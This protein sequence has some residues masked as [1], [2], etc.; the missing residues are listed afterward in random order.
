M[1][2]L[3]LFVAR[4]ALNFKD[5]AYHTEWV[6]Y[7]DIA[8][9]FKA[10]G[11]LPNPE[12]TVPNT[13]TIPTVRLGSGTYVVDSKQI[14]FELEKLQPEPSLHLESPLW[15]QAQQAVM[16]VW[17]ALIPVIMPQVPRN[18]LNPTSME[19]FE[20]TRSERF[21]MPLDEL[22]ETKGGDKAWA[23]AQEPIRQ[24]T[25]L[26]KANEGPYFMGETGRPRM[27]TLRAF[28]T[29]IVVVPQPR[30]QTSWPSPHSIA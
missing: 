16:K 29:L 23:A 10:L 3:T 11:I 26:L 14:A 20:R 22:E 17:T 13:Y 6:E 9:K 8:P 30:M 4:M 1:H 5:I 28:Q 2:A 21:G 27:Y 24:L 7:P 12:G 19:Y 15:E 18:L 25:D